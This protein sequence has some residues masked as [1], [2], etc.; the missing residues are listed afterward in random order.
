MI[1]MMKR[2]SAML[3]LF[4]LVASLFFPMMNPSY[5]VFAAVGE[6]NGATGTAKNGFST[7]VNDLDIS[8]NNGQLDLGGLDDDKDSSQD[9]VWTKLFTEYRGIIVGLSGVAAITMIV[10][11]IINF[12]KLGAAS[13]NPQARTQAIMGLIWTGL[14]AAGCGG[15][16]IFVGFFYNMMR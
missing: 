13:G 14:A 8:Y 9:S 1:S 12:M 6:N 15:V 4:L 11:F 7:N 3:V 5:S 10:F 2:S 16:S